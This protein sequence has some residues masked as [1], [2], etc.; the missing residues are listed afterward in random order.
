MDM[1]AD[2]VDSELGDDRDRLVAMM[3]TLVGSFPQ[4]FHPGEEI[5]VRMRM[6]FEAA[7]CMLTALRFAADY[8][9]EQTERTPTRLH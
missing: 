5:D 2:R 9:G 3:A 1:R 7:M 4:G 8:L 6:S